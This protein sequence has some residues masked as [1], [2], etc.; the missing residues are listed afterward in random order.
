MSKQSIFSKILFSSLPRRA[1]TLCFAVVVSCISG[2]GQI[3][4]GAE[5][6]RLSGK[7]VPLPPQK[8]SFLSAPTYN[9]RH[10][11]TAVSVAPKGPERASF[12]RGKVVNSEKLLEADGQW[13]VVERGRGLDPAQAHLNA[14]KNVNV[15][16]RRTDNTLSA[17]F[18]PNAPSGKD[19]KLRVLHLEAENNIDWD[20][21]DAQDDTVQ[22]NV[23]QKE[24]TLSVSG[25]ISSFSVPSIFSKDKAKETSKKGD[26]NVVPPT[27][28]VRKREVK[29]EVQVAKP[30]KSSV[31]VAHKDAVKTFPPRKPELPSRQSVKRGVVKIESAKGAG[32]F[33]PIPTIKPTRT[34]NRVYKN[35]KV[36]E[37]SINVYKVRSGVHP[38]KTRV[39]IEVSDKTQYKTTIDPIRNVL[40]VKLANA[41][42]KAPSQAILKGSTLLGTYVAR[43]QGDGSALLEIRL[44]RSSKILNTMIL[45]P[46][47]SSH[48]RIVIDLNG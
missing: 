35:G 15:K 4:Y 25:L 1:T 24:D 20:E 5:F 32:D 16:R 44:K 8:P 47:S 39:V 21:Y 9:P 23:K 13:S 48:Y 11:K 29:K 33:V 30:V 18:E 2:G 22:E 40:R 46:G 31:V 38:G 37:N 14:R 17:H 28:P 6:V 10:A 36:S 45:E 43:V 12:V 42:W 7:L 41:N 19:G 34:E 3:A 26:V 27:L